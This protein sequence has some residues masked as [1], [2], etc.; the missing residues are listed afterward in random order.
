MAQGT[1]MVIKGRKVWRTTAE[2]PLDFPPG[3][4]A[5]ASPQAAPATAADAP[6]KPLAPAGQRPPQGNGGIEVNE[7]AATL[8]AEIYNALFKPAT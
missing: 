6:K 5:A 8:P 1:H 2:S 3:A 7:F 4:E